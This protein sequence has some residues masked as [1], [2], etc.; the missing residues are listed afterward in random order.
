MIHNYLKIAWRNIL[1]NK[2]FSVINI[3]GLSLGIAVCVLITLY[4]KDEFTFDQ[5]Q[6]NKQNIYRLVVDSKTGNDPIEHY[7]VTGMKHGEEFK[8][9]V[10]EVKSM[11]RLAGKRFNIRHNNE[12]LVQEASQVDSNFFTIFTADFI[13]GSAYKALDS[14]NS[15]VISETVAKRFFG[16]EKAL[17]K[18]LAI[19]VEDEFRNFTIA[20]VIQ[21]SPQNSTIQNNLLMP[22]D[23]S[24]KYENFWM[25]FYLSTFFTF[26]PNAQVSSIEKKF[27]VIYANDSKEEFAQAKKE[28]NFNSLYTFRLQ[29]FLDI[30]LNRTYQSGGGLKKGG[31]PLFSYFLSGI[32][33]FILIIACTNFVNISISHSSQRSKEIGVRKV[34]GGE[35]QNLIFQ[36]LSESF[37]LNLCAFLLALVWV[38]MTLPTFNGLINKSLSLSYLFDWKLIGIFGGLFLLTGFLA[39]FYPALVLSSY[40]P[41]DTLYGRFKIKGKN[42]LQ[43]SLIIFQFGLATFF[44]IMTLVQYRQVDLFTS[45]SLGYDDKNLVVINT[46]SSSKEKGEIFMEELKR[47]PNIV[48]TA[49]RNED[50]G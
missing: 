4:V 50:P 18:F 17:G 22:F 36:F 28:Y 11:V 25:N 7:G 38:Q 46:N 29:P 3:L 33:L 40:Q 37:T 47:N 5:F 9:Q 27:E 42:L 48:A 41:V 16:N 30:H 8:K 43:K 19:D 31:N 1:K 45:K 23:Y 21:N 35:R 39:G 15:I 12:V 44:I 49:A 20:G 10:P 26:T 14:P 6:E 13:E 24:K 2:V 32:A 34:M